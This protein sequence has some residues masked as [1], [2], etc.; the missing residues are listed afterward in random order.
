MNQRGLNVLAVVLLVIGIACGLLYSYAPAIGV[1]IGL[2]FIMTLVGMIIKRL[3]KMHEIM[4]RDYLKRYPEENKTK[5]N[6]TA[7][8]P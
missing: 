1:A 7:E 6:A 2:F 8:K 5:E 4:K 3:D